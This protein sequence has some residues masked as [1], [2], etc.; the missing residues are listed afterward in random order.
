MSV[1]LVCCFGCVGVG[2]ARAGVAGRIG[3][4][5]GVGASG[6]L[7]C[8][9]C[10]FRVGGCCAGMAR[11]CRVRGGGGVGVVVRCGIR[12]VSVGCVS[13]SGGVGCGCS[14]R[15]CVCVRLPALWV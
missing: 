14:C 3:G 13:V 11:V 4:V 5:V 10:A 9:V 8:Y 2:V 6:V 7:F 1:A 15:R 12:V